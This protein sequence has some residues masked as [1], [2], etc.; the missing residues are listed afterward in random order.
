MDRLTYTL[1]IKLKTVLTKPN[2]FSRSICLKLK[3]FAYFPKNVSYW[4]RVYKFLNLLFKKES[5]FNEN[6]VKL[7]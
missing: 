5:L 1:L 2:S 7:V 3:I 4:L 6:L